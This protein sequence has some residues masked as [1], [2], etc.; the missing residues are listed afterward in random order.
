MVNGAKQHTGRFAAS[1]RESGQWGLVGEQRAGLL[2][3]LAAILEGERARWFYWIPVLFGAG[4]A[5]YFWLPFEPWMLGSLA[6]AGACVS[7][8]WAV[9]SRGG[10]LTVILAAAAI[11]SMGFLAAKVRTEWVR[12]PVLDAPTSRGLLRGHLEGIEPRA[13]RGGVRLTVLVR[14]LGRLRPYRTPRRVRF[15]SVADMTGFAVGDGIRVSVHLSPPPGPVWPGG[16]DFARYAWFQGLGGVG[17][18]ISEPK[19]DDTLGAPPL[20]LRLMAGVAS[21]R[22]AIS[23]RVRATLDG[24]TGAI[25]VALIS[26]ERGGI[27]QATN[28]AFRDS[29]LF[30]ILSIS[31]LHM[32]IMGGAVFFFVRAVLALFPPIA[33]RYPI[34]KWAAVAAIIGSFAYLLISGGA[35]PTVRSFLMISVMFL[36]VLL[37]RPALALRNVAVAA[38]LILIV[39]PEALNN[40]GFQMSFAAVVV[41]VSAFEG[42]RGLERRWFAREGYGVWVV[43]AALAG[44]VISTL[45]ASAAV[46]PF[47]AYHFHKS[48]QYAVLANLLAVPVCNL[49]VMPA[50]LAT[51][52]L[53]PLGL[54][55]LALVAMGAGIDVMI[56]CAHQ[57]AALPGATSRVPSIPTVAFALMVIGGLWLCLMHLRWRWAGLA[58]ILSGLLIAPWQVRPD[59]LVGRKGQTVAVRGWDGKLRA[60]KMMGD[61]Y[62]LARWLEHDG[63]R[64]PVDAAKSRQA[65]ACDASGCVAHV[66]GAVVAVSTHVRSLREDCARS[67]ILI[68][69]GRRPGWCTGPALVID[70]KARRSQGMH[71]VY[72]EPQRLAQEVRHVPS[73]EPSETAA[74]PAD[75]NTVASQRPIAIQDKTFAPITIRAETVGQYR[76]H[77]PWVR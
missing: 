38:L 18:A 6:A 45:L 24:Q 56:W 26:G 16:F 12:A 5:I 65:F 7:L 37:D 58:L 48:Q 35:A 9:S 34:K 17:Y 59:V 11:V 77:R 44:I 15:T 19:H 55:T 8:R 57:V 72:L 68:V 50:A 20:Q 23:D 31:G 4:I 10:L 60:L 74:A 62:Q 66:K 51:L 42:G 54:E 13:E 69:T 2:A 76:G 28:D 53:M 52:V 75:A 21:V 40:A 73:S 61:D 43:P 22:R 71:A 32:A 29:G 25:A 46:A 41:L 27:T 33:E 67:Q 36:A 63:D 30:H 64:R 14:S 1:G 47:A 39:T 49:V 3:S 70:A